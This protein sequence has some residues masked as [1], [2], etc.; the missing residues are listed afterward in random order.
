VAT[1]AELTD[2]VAA[3]SAVAVAALG[4]SVHIDVTGLEPDTEYHYRF[5]LAEFATPPAHP[6]RSKCPD[7]DGTGRTYRDDSARWI[8]R[9]G[10]RALRRAAR[11]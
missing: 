5:R 11:R 10:S 1:D 9:R 3:G 4:H 2:V 6:A 7:G 8:T